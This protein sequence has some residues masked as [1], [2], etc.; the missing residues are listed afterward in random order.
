MLKR[1]SM[2]GAD[3]AVTDERIADLVVE[4]AKLLGRAGT[5]DTVT[6]PVVTDGVADEA[7]F[8][9]GPA[10][11]IAITSSHDPSLER[12]PLLHVS[13]VVEDLRAR[14]GRLPGGTGRP[15]VAENLLDG[16]MSMLDDYGL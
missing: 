4:Y 7:T 12:I 1:I 11:Q 6:L 9:L 13:E 2:A 8:L 5:T 14:I 16:S 15:V 3:I 10:S